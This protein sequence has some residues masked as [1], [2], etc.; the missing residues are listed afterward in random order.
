MGN[1]S[2]NGRIVDLQEYVYFRDLNKGPR[3]PRFVK[4]EQEAQV[5][6]P[7]MGGNI[8]L[9]SQNGDAMVDIDRIKRSFSPTN[10]NFK[11][12]VQINRFPQLEKEDILIC[13]TD[14][15]EGM[16]EDTVGFFGAGQTDKGDSCTQLLKH[17]LNLPYTEIEIG[18]HVGQVDISHYARHCIATP[19]FIEELNSRVVIHEI[20]HG[21][22]AAHIY[23]TPQILSNVDDTM[24]YSTDKYFM[25]TGGLQNPTFLDFHSENMSR[26]RKFSEAVQR[27]NLTSEEVISLR[28]EYVHDLIVLYNPNMQ[29]IYEVPE[30]EI[31]PNGILAHS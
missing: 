28:D 21:L 13:L 26:I 15:I 25:G 30:A 12:I 5:R 1:K 11:N 19:A 14:K 10:I 20:A 31:H 2:V 17:H 6:E 16:D 9:H 22:G 27:G 3:N 29:E 18:A 24:I 8:Y 23:T 4:Y 7:I